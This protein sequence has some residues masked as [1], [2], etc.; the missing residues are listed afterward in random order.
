MKTES[1]ISKSGFHD[2]SCVLKIRGKGRGVR[3]I[4]FLSLKTFFLLITVSYLLPFFSI[5]LLI[6]RV[7]FSFL[8]RFFFSV[9]NDSVIIRLTL[10]EIE[11]LG[12]VKL[13]SRDLKFIPSYRSF[14][15]KT[16]TPRGGGW[17]FGTNLEGVVDYTS[18]VARHDRTAVDNLRAEIER[19]IRADAAEAAAPLNQRS[20]ERCTPAYHSREELT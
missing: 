19:K 20:R 2:W 9:S 1:C 11:P 8:F 10:F 14:Y 3:G 17:G 16:Y 12:K 18:V 15:E 5:F 7:N 6:E 4:I 13:R